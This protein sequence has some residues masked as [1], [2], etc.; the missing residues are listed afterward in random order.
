M[1]E[2]VAFQDLLNINEILVQRNTHLTNE[3]NNTFVIRRK[4]EV[5]LFPSVRTKLAVSL[6]AYQIEFSK[7]L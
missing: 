6:R 5:T 7:Y 4:L 3:L 2:N 1:G